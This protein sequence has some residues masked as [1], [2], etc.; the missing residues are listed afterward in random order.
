MANI[1][2]NEAV[3]TEATTEATNATEFNEAEMNGLSSEDMQAG[4]GFL[5]AGG[6]VALAY[7]AGFKSGAKSTL[8]KLEVALEKYNITGDS[9]T[10]IVAAVKDAKK[11]KKVKEKKEH[12]PMK[13]F[14]YELSLNKVKPE[15]SEKKE[16]EEKTNNS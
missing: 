8:K 12:K 9:A 1:E 13:L 7:T 14:G 11:P 15:E 5:A 10:L 2:N 16:N 4:M 6:M 3:A